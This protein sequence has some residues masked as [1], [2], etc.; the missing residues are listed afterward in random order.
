MS[1]QALLRQKRWVNFDPVYRYCELTDPDKDSL[2]IVCVCVCVQSPSLRLDASLNH[3][4]SLIHGL[5]WVLLVIKL[6]NS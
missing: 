3:S 1:V 4:C 5:N 6:L 2:S